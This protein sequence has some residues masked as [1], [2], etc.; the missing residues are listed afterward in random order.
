MRRIAIVLACVLALAAS[1]CAS[2]EGRYFREGI[3]TDLYWSGLPEATRL[4]ELYLGFICQ[5]AGLLTVADSGVILCAYPSMTPTE[6]A[7]FVQA[8]MNDIDRRCDAY[9]AWLDDKRRV[10]EPVLKQ[11]ADM[12]AATAGILQAANVGAAPIAIV[13]IA[14]GL[15][16]DTF[17]NVT[18]RLLLEIDHSAIQA[19]V[20]DYQSK[21]RASNVKVIIDNRPAAIYLLRAYL[22]LCIPYS[23]ETSINTTITIYHRDPAALAMPPLLLRTPVAARL[24][25]AAAFRESVPSGGPRGTLPGVPGQNSHLPKFEL[26]VGG[27]NDFERKLRKTTGQKIQRNLCVA[28]SGEFD[29]DTRSALAQAKLGARQSN[30]RFPGKP[31]FKNIIGGLTSDDE[32]QIFQ[33]MTACERDIFGN[34][35]KYQTAFEKFRFHNEGLVKMFQDRLKKCKGVG[36]IVTNGIFDDDTRKAIEKVKNGADDESKKGF[37]FP[38]TR[39]MDSN[40]WQYIGF[41]CN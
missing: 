8:G 10:R 9:L 25:T 20:L 29:P 32:V 33:G 37:A 35:R 6:W 19:V 22:R 31:P 11:L 13:G 36:E 24:Q 15:A 14:F 12:G 39:K 40:V 38:G 34:D 21:F 3:G 18:S 27:N 26:M 5:Q 23:I 4:Q 41:S 30:L 17:T 16:A 28:Q 2:L 7:L 1:A